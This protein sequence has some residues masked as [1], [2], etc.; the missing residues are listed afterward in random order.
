MQHAVI[1]ICFLKTSVEIN[2][3]VLLCEQWGVQ[4]EALFG[5]AEFALLLGRGGGRRFLAVGDVILRNL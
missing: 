1:K 5:L 3:A 2:T 4:S